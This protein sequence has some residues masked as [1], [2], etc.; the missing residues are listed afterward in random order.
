MD[1][2]QVGEFWH[3]AGGAIRFRARSGGVAGTRP[4]ATVCQP[5]GLTEL[6]GDRRN[7]SI[8]NAIVSIRS[9]LRA[10][11][12]LGGLGSGKKLFWARRSEGGA[13][14]WFGGW[15]AKTEGVTPFR[16]G[17]AGDTLR[18]SPPRSGREAQRRR[19]GWMIRKLDRKRGGGPPHYRTLRA[20]LNR[21]T[22]SFAI[23]GY[24]ASFL[25]GP[26]DTVAGKQGFHNQSARRQRRKAGDF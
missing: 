1:D 6:P 2:R 11:I 7:A 8:C 22:S 25:R 10:S 15:P 4:P 14:E 13:A 18:V 5:A 17:S 21:Y 20:F 12:R 23:M 26:E 16:P 9:F 3:P 24:A 19:C